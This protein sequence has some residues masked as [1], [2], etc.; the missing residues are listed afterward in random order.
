MLNPFTLRLV[1]SKYFCSANILQLPFKLANKIL[2]F[3]K[4]IIHKRCHASIINVWIFRTHAIGSSFG[5]WCLK[6]KKKRS[7][8]PCGVVLLHRWGCSKEALA[9]PWDTSDIEL[10]IMS[11]ICDALP[12]WHCNGHLIQCIK[13]KKK[14][15]IFLLLWSSIA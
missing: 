1:Y 3:I 4:L 2:L 14:K 11:Q 13:K 6:K 15:K 5:W 12:I 10:L 9:N 8:K 7:S